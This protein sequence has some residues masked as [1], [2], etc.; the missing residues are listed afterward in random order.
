[1]IKVVILFIKSRRGIEAVI[2]RRSWKPF[3]HKAHGFESHHL[4]HFFIFWFSLSMQKY[5]SWWRGA[6][7]KGVGRVTGAR[8]RVPPSAPEKEIA[9]T[10]GF[11]CFFLTYAVFLT[12]CCVQSLYEKVKFKSKSSHESIL[13][14]YLRFNLKPLNF[15]INSG[16]FYV[17]LNL[18]CAEDLLRFLYF[19]FVRSSDSV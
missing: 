3:A 19:S 8:V 14:Q 9:L 16:V 15:K 7:A 12:F 13:F 6:P 10:C 1:M 4:R 18:I 2:T 17:I 11:F 5:S